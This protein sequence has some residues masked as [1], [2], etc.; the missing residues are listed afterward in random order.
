MPEGTS[1]FTCTIRSDRELVMTRV[2]HAPR[3]RIFQASTDPR[4][5]PRW[6]GPRVVTTIVE[7]MDVRPGGAWRF[8]RRAADG[9]AYAFFGEYLEV[10]PPER[11]VSIFEFTGIPCVASNG[12][13]DAG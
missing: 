8:V 13:L 9:N 3:E 4:A 12:R 7:T 2:F 10:E 6:R 1:G 11:L 5:I